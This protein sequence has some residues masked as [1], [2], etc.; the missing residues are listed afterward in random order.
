MK[1]C[2]IKPSISICLDCEVIDP[3]WGLVCDCENC[4][5]E[6]GNYELLKIGVGTMFRRDYAMVLIDGKVKRVPL[7][8]IYDIREV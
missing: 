2:R 6:V 1:V 8:D 5:R 7:K 4:P 3:D